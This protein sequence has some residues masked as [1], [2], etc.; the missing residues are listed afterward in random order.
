[1]HSTVSTS[2]IQKHY[3]FPGNA[4]YFI[5]PLVFIYLFYLT[6]VLVKRTFVSP[7][8]KSDTLHCEKLVGPSLWEAAVNRGE[9]PGYS[10]GHSSWYWNMDRSLGISARLRISFSEVWKSAS[11]LLVYVPH[12][13]VPFSQHKMN[14]VLQWKIMLCTEALLYFKEF[15]DV[16]GLRSFWN[17]L[18]WRSSLWENI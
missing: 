6:E 18:W 14:R 8:W 7:K 4:M 13:T 3:Q 5:F 2:Q 11:S 12:R 16:V 10:S 17:F 9:T 15:T 1:M